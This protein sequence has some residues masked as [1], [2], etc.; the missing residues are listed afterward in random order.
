MEAQVMDQEKESLMNMLESLDLGS[1][2][3]LIY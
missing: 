2:E 1:S 3:V